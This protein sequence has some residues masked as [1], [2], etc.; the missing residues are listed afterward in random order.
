MQLFSLQEKAKE[1]AIIRGLR[2]V[3]AGCWL[4]PRNYG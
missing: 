3:A 1:E 2:F 4:L